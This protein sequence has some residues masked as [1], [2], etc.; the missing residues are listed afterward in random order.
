MGSVEKRTRTNKNGTKTTFW[1]ARWR[2]PGSDRQPSKSFPKKGLAQ[3][4]LDE[5]EAD[6][7][8]GEYITVDAG[9]VTFSEYAEEWL[10]GKTFDPNT[11]QSVKSRLENH[12]YETALGSRHLSDIKP[13]TIRA[14]LADVKAAD[15]TRGVIFG[16][17]SSVLAAAVDDEL[18]KRNPCKAK[19]VAKPKR[20]QKK[21]APWESKTVL[22]VRDGL[23]DRYKIVATLGAG[24]GLRQGEIFGLAVE[25]IDDEKG[26]VTI[27][28]QVKSIGGTRVFGLPKHDKTRDV[29][30]PKSVRNEISAHLAK[31]SPVSVSLPWKD[32]DGEPTTARLV[33]TNA[34]GDAVKASTFN[35]NIWKRVLEQVGLLDDRENGCHMLRHVYASTLLHY[36]ESIKALSEY[37]GHADPGFTLRVYTH[38]MPGSAE[39][40][41][42]AVDEMFRVTHVEREPD[43]DANGQ[44]RAA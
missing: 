41:R 8:R 15:S 2:E 24:L 3:D 32:A 39:R 27:R 28:R 30:L 12:V 13:S 29:P 34:N 18:I 7:H 25:D 38:L 40:T 6:I 20:L 42:R 26:I 37:L 36:G 33:L 43:D 23:P 4:F 11:R 1:V 9:K 16:H 31:H 17:V 14:W 19:S 5:I 44:V 10:K 35:F 22:A 21:I